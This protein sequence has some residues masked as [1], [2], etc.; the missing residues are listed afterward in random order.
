M[1]FTCFLLLFLR[2]VF[3]YLV[4]YWSQIENQKHF[5]D[6]IAKSRN[7]DP[8]SARHW[9][10]VTKRDVL[11]TK[12]NKYFYCYYYFLLFCYLFFIICFFL[13]FGI[14]V[15]WQGGMGLLHHYK[16]SHVR[17]LM[18]VYPDIGLN[19]RMFG[20]WSFHFYFVIFSICNFR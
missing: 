10:F 12:V 5:F 8:L 14:Y 4:N 13:F 16:G 18:A 20:Y 7:F 15:Y 19:P 3:Y 11:R 6:E 9:H 1:C 2:F 17:A